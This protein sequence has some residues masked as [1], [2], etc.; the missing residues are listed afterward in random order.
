MPPTSRSVLAALASIMMLA[1]A[2]ASAQDHSMHDH[3]AAMAAPSAPP[4]YDDLGT[5][6]FA[7][8]TKSQDAQKYFDQGMR[9]MW[10]F[11]LEEAERA[12]EQ[13]EALDPTSPMCAW[14][15]AFSLGPHINFPATPDRTVKA[16]AAVQ[17]ASKLAGNATPL[18]KSLIEAMSKRY[19][20]PAPTTPEGQ[21]ALNQA[22]SDAMHALMIQNAANVDVTMLWVESAMDLHPWD[23]YEVDGTPK[24]WTGEIVTT[25]EKVLAKAPNHPGANHFYIH[26]VEAS[27]T[28]ERALASAKR[29]ETAM[30]GAGHL[31]HMPSHIYKRVGRY[32]ASV[33]WNR[34]AIAVDD[35]F[36]ASQNPQGFY[37]MYVAHNH[38]FLMASC[39]M[40]G[41]AEEALKEA[42]ATLEVIPV[43]MLRQMPGFDLVLGYP[44]W[45]MARF[46][47]W[48]EALSEPAP[49]S[50]FAYAVG[51]WHAAR[52]LAHASLGNVD[53]A[54]IER[55]SVVALQKTIPAEQVEGYNSAQTLLSIALGVANGTIAA[56]QG[57]TDDAVKAL[58]EAVAL[59]DGLRYDEPSDWYFPVR[60]ALGAV[61]LDANRAKE[62]QAVYEKDLLR[63]PENGWALTGLAKSLKAQKKPATAV[64]S[65]ASKAWKDADVKIAGSWM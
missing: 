54:M 5:Y 21:T 28:P 52:A 59:E 46:G 38:Q 4:L 13:A 65:R 7:I 58:T 17:R 11:N 47:R 36:R 53:K 31:V 32:D 14:G 29:L 41:Q 49:P 48:N 15:T 6:H 50:D 33:D 10:G 2:Q 1:A 61:L 44:I 34:K 12:F 39:W 56:K 45:T 57:K 22:Y 26:A 62:A 63:N 19:S 24:A 3:P 20:D 60:H 16:N 55:D 43:D 27:K 40:T 30:P 37:L 64:E 8:S 25:L 18:E 51:V 35:K 9:L 23:L 42:R